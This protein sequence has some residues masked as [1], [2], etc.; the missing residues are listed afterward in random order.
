MKRKN[1]LLALTALVLLL[2]V[3]LALRGASP[4][5]PEE[6]S[7]SPA[8]S[9]ASTVEAT[10]TASPPPESAASP[11]SQANLPLEGESYYDLENVVLY[12]ELYNA[13]PQNYITKREAR[14]LG[15]SGG[16]VERYLEGAA[17]GGDRFGNRE[18]QLPNAAE[19]YYT[20]CDL[21]TRGKDSRG[22]ERLCFSNDGLYF[23]TAD[24]YGHFTQYVVTESWEVIPK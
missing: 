2:A 3:P 14:E 17:I 20:E 15:W 7:L 16:S 6:T 11:F 10:P 13:L 1:F 18:G 8:V 4:T 24:H 9:S 23:Y 19:R 12:L 21:N 22:A 5:V